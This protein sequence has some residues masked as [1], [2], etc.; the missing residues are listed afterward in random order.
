MSDEKKKGIF[1]EIYS[2]TEEGLKM[3]MKPVVRKQVKGTLSSSYNDAESK[4]ITAESKI[5]ELRTDIKNFDV[6][7]ILEQRQIITECRRLQKFIANEYKEL[8][9]KDMPVDE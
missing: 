9:G 2:R 6:N 5:E 4:K 8:F 7:A 3:V 1:D